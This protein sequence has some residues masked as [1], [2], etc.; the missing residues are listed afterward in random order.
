MDIKEI[1]NQQPTGAITEISK[2]S[3][4]PYSTVQAVLSGRRTASDIKVFEATTKFL[5][6]YKQ[7]KR[8]AFQK[9]QAVANS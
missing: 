6:N 8:D 4:I 9:L 2:E 1:K 3:G 7:K 5:D